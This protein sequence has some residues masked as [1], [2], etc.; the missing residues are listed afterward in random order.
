MNFLEFI[1]LFVGTATASFIATRFVLHFLKSK[2]IVDTPNTRSS[3]KNPI[4]RGGGIAVILV[5]LTV[6]ILILKGK[7]PGYHILF[8]T[9]FFIGLIS[10]FDD[11]RGLS[12]FFRLFSQFAAVGCIFW[13]IPTS[14][15]YFHGLFPVYLDNFLAMILWVWFINLFNFMDGIDGITVVESSSIGLGIFLIMMIGSAEITHGLL[16]LVIAAATLGFL[17]WNWQPAK[18]FLGDVGSIPLGFLL[19]WL[20]LEILASAL[21]PVAIILPLY[22]LTD[23]TI[24]LIRRIYRKE[25]IWQAHREHFYQQAIDHGL[26]HAQVS[27]VIAGFNLLLI[28]FGFLSLSH[29]LLAIVGAVICVS[30]EIVYL[31]KAK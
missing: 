23:T 28:G 11:L 4:P 16:G 5:I 29:P 3:H 22:Y 30:G 25:H 26:S 19:G 1:F 27:L 31:S 14:N 6:S 8:I 18:L 24:T 17:W 21:W 15:L 9:T 20:L 7:I 2:D 12:A 10:W 13:L